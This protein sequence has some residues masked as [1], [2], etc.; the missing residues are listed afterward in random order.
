[1]D[2][3]AIQSVLPSVM[4]QIEAYHRMTPEERG[5][6]RGLVRRSLAKVPLSDKGGI[7]TEM[8]LFRD[9]QRRF[10]ILVSRRSDG[11][12]SA[13]V[14]A[15]EAG[16]PSNAPEATIKATLRGETNAELVEQFFQIGQQV[17]GDADGE[18][19]AGH[20]LAALMHLCSISQSELAKL[21]GCTVARIAM[22]AKRYEDDKA[23]MRILAEYVKCKYKK[24]KVK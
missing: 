12:I 2:Q 24:V 23:T 15:F 16:K 11:T 10:G 9:S 14:L 22:S 19:V 17:C 5:R 20:V 7:L 18:D 6:V 3:A 21:T 1:M 4:A 13:R 8:G